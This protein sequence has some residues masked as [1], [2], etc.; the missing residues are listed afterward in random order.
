[1]RS[2]EIEAVGVVVPARDEE[3]LLPAALQALAVAVD[4]VRSTCAVTVD[5]VVVLDDCGDGSAAVVASHPEVCSISTVS[6]NVGLARAAGFSHL[7][8]DHSLA[9]ARELWLAS[10]DA[11]SRVPRDWLVRQLELARSGADLVVGTVDVDDW[12]EHPR[13]VEARWRATY[14]GTDGHRHVHGANVGMRA[15]VYVETGGFS[16]LAVDEDV[17]IV[18]SMRGHRIVRTGSIPVLTSGRSS[19][20][21]PGGFADFITALGGVSAEAARAP[22]PPARS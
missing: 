1:M 22:G 7:I 3:V 4:R 10:T 8:S 13:D 12:S 19:G 14:D 15:D 21:C 9:S 6:G 2:P 16:G 5:V 18:T 17:A 20:R 11:D